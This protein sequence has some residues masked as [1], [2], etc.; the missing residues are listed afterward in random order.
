MNASSSTIIEEISIHC[1]SDPSLA[2]AYFYFDFNSSSKDTLSD[3]ILRSMLK[4][5]STQCESTPSALDK[6]FTENA[7]ANRSPAHGELM[8]TLKSIIA[9]FR[10]VYVIFDA[11]DECQERSRLLKVVKEIYDWKLDA[12]H[13]LATSR[14]EGDIEKS[15]SGLVSHQVPMKED[16]VDRDIQVYV[17]ETLD[18]DTRFKHFFPK[19]KDLI[20]ST[21]VKDAHGM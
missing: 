5:L 15:L 6:L 2:I 17:S 8:F 13:L 16:L 3:A 14:K 1:R 21:L 11:L 19:H 12:L 4:Q 18:H 10:A 9:N 7:A 20:E